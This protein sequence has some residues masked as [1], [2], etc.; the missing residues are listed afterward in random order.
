MI[1][2][3]KDYIGI[4][5]RLGAEIVRF[6]DTGRHGKIHLKAGGKA[7]WFSVPRS[8]SDVRAQHNFR[9]EVRRWMTGRSQPYGRAS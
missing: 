1:R 5:E 9:A 2:S 4:A 8:P 7:G 3:F 6:D